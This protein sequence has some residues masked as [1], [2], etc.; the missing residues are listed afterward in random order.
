MCITPLSSKIFLAL[1]LAKGEF[2]A[3]TQYLM[4]SGKAA[5]TSSVMARELAHG[6][7]KSHGVLAQ[8]LIGVHPSILAASGCKSLLLQAIANQ[9]LAGK[10]VISPGMSLYIFYQPSMIYQPSNHS[11]LLFGS[12]V[13]LSSPKVP[14]LALLSQMTSICLHPIMSSL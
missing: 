3:P 8:S 12:L 14:A 9:I 2:V 5:A 10:Q 6:T 13:L 11:F 7:K 1:S 4:P